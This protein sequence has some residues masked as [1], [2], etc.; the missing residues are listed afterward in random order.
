[1]SDNNMS[2]LNMDS[3]SEISNSDVEE[4]RNIKL[5]GRNNKKNGITLDINL[6]FM[7]SI[8]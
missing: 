8:F 5:N 7:L 3:G 4:I 1:M 6:N 2:N